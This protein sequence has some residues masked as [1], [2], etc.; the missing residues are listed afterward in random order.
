MRTGY[1][2]VGH[3]GPGDAR[4]HEVVLLQHVGQAPGREARVVAPLV[5]LQ[6]IIVSAKREHWSVRRADM[7]PTNRTNE[8]DAGEQ[9]NCQRELLSKNI[10][11]DS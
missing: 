5:D 2:L 10:E 1:D 4:D 9:G 11:Q 6:S 7:Q 8:A 3:R